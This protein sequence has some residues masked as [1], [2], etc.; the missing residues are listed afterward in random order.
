MTREGCEARVVRT[1][2][3]ATPPATP[4]ARHLECDT[5][6]RPSGVDSFVFLFPT[7]GALRLFLLGLRA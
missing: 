7:L 3:A 6:S 1:Q 5:E 2:A 4:G